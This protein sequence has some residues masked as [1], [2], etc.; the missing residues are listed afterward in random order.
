MDKR[1]TALHLCT[2]VM[3]LVLAIPVLFVDANSLSTYFFSGAYISFVI[4]Y[5][6]VILLGIAF[7]RCADK[8][9]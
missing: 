1:L 7:S 2:I 9:A 5:L 8:E 6:C 4:V 3:I